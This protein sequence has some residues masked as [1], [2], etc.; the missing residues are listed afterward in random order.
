VTGPV[1]VTGAAGFA[2][3]HL[4]ELLAGQGPV[5]AFSRSAPAPALAPLATWFH[6]DLLDR[7]AVQR[8]IDDIRPQRI[9][10]CAGAPHIATSWK[11]TAHALRA[12]VL[13]THHLFEAVRR[14][15]LRCRVLVT[16]SAAVYAPSADRLRE[17]DVLRPVSPYGV[18]KLA[19]EQLSLLAGAETGVDVIVTR[20]FNHT[21]PRQA[22]DFAAPAMAR[23][24]ALIERGAA[25]PVLH[26]GN[27]DPVRD[28]TDVRD[29]VR[30]Y[31]ALMERGTPGSVYNVGSGI[32]RSIRAVVDALLSRSAIPVE[33]RVDPARLRPHDTPVVVG[34][35]DKLREATGWEPAIPFERM[36]DDLLAHWRTRTAGEPATR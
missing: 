28:I 14:A 9:F 11:D 7:D 20:S 8:A 29:M 23:Q 16:G 35:P 18:S 1:L 4:L 15:K 26:V 25:P 36:I 13:T 31:A 30:A 32:G 34:N 5:T 6:V 22:A 19:Q 21:G 27:L 12:N 3:G 2:G 24:V 10:H 33:F 17:D